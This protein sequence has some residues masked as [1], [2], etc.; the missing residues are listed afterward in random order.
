MTDKVASPAGL[1]S[2]RKLN[3]N[4][5]S[6][7]QNQLTALQ[8]LPAEPFLVIGNIWKGEKGIILQVL[9]SNW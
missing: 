5:T 6:Q 1:H 2:T 4:E 9:H 8:M 7:L 3:V